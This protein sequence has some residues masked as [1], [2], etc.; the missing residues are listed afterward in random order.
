MLRDIVVRKPFERL[1]CSEFKNRRATR[2]GKR[3]GNPKG[4]AGDSTLSS[5]LRNGSRPF[6]GGMAY[7]RALESYLTDKGGVSDRCRHLLG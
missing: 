4:L 6:K 1:G 2:E 5:N 3:G 7:E